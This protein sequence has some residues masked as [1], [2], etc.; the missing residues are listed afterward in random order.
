MRESRVEWAEFVSNFGGGDLIKMT[1]TS[2]ARRP[3]GRPAGWLA[4]SLL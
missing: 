1:A 3:V 4:A 2:C